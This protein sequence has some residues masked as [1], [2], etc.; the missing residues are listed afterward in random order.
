MC[1]K[2]GTP[3]NC[4]IVLADDNTTALFVGGNA[5]GEFNADPDIAGIGVLGAFI[6]V[7]TLSLILAFWGMVWW[8]AKK[9][10]DAVDVVASMKRG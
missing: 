3:L 7:T 4:S 5:P 2:L 9:I 10:L 1:C 6:A 8:V